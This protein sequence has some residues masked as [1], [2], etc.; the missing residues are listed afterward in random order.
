MKILISGI[1]GFVGSSLATFLRSAMAGAEIGGFDNFIRPG[2]ERNRRL[3]R[4]R[5]I[6]VVHADLRSA[7]DID[8]LPRADFVI[9]AAANPS[10]LAG[11]DGR[12]GSRQVG[13][14]NLLGTLNLLEYCRRHRAGLVLLSSSRVYSIPALAALP[15]RGEG[16]AFALEAGAALPVGLSA[17]GIGEGFS[18]AAPLSLYGA[19]KLASEVMALEYGAAF[20]F[21]VW[22]NRCGVLAGAGQFGRAEQGIFSYWLHAWHA[23]RPLRYIGFGGHG[24]QV[25]D[26]L[27]P[28]DPG[29]A[30]R[31]ATGGRG[32]A[33]RAG[34]QRGGRRGERAVAAAAERVVRG[35]LGRAEDRA[36][37]GVAALRSAVDRA[38]CGGGGSRVAVAAGD[39]APGDP[40]GDRGACGGES[41]LA[42]PVHAVS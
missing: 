38:G 21:P 3:L 27:H 32:A 23:Q 11:V 16:D 29:A 28:R 41:G 31:A 10:V 18:T 39:R 20:D 5:G 2:S 15:L 35:A 30:D 6:Q 22:I 24:R 33:P 40:G 13:E 12:A 36:A 42:G 4:E 25:R 19:T 8:S 7:S 9:D 17:R 34:V 1:C 26:A 14:H 37:A